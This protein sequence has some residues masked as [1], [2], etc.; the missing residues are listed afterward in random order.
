MCHKTLAVLALCIIMS[1]ADDWTTSSSSFIQTFHAAYPCVSHIFAD[2][3]GRFKSWV[4]KGM[5]GSQSP[6]GDAVKSHR[7]NVWWDTELPAPPRLTVTVTSAKLFVTNC[8]TQH[9]DRPAPCKH[10]EHPPNSRHH[11]AIEAHLHIN[12]RLWFSFSERLQKINPPEWVGR[13]NQ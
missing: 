10:L 7:C 8:N 9:L 6:V 13:T 4:I 2:D 11:W 5:C 1:P 3:L 12:K